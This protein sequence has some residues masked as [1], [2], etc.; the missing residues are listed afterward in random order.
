MMTKTRHEMMDGRLHVY[1]REGSRL[2]Q[3]STFLNERN[4]RTSTK[5]D[6]LAEAKD[7]AED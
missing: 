4:W 3:C 7:F 1:T 6:S 5:T 2:W